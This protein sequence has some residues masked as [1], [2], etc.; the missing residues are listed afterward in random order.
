M[1]Y[2]TPDPVFSQRMTTIFHY[3]KQGK[4]IA[5]STPTGTMKAEYLFLGEV[6]VGVFK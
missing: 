2:R 4:L 3:D 1:Q 6:P 5:E